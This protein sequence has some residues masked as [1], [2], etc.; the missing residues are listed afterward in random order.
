MSRSDS[1]KVCAKNTFGPFFPVLICNIV[2]ILSEGE[3]ER[4]SDVIV[5]CPYCVLGDEFRPM[6]RSRSWFTCV[7]CG[8]RAH[9]DQV[10]AR[11]A[12]PKCQEM[13]LLASRCKTSEERKNLSAFA[14]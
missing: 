11:C 8:H 12:C 9:P 3:F 13:N 7:V 10:S 2:P 5:R 1:T 4:M 14:S 6:S